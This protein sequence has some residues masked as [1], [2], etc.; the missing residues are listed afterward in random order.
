[1][2]RKIMIVLAMAAVLTGGLTADAFARGGGGGGTVV[3]SA[4]AAI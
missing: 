4:A 1:M 2:T 3:G